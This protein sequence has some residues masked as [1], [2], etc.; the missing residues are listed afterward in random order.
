MADGA[1]NK[2]LLDMDKKETIKNATF[3]D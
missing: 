3:E 1:L 2:V